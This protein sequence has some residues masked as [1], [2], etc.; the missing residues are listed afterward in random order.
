MQTDF[1]SM[2]GARGVLSLMPCKQ[3]SL[4]LAGIADKAGDGRAVEVWWSE[5]ALE[6]A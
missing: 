4:D 6:V 3:G 5:S 2:V 1:L